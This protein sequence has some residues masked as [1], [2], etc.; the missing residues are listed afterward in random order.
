MKDQDATAT[1]GDWLRE[2]DGH[3][4]AEVAAPGPVVSVTIN[5]TGPCYHLA[6]N[7]IERLARLQGEEQTAEP[8][9]T[10]QG[11]YGEVEMD[12]VVARVASVA[13]RTRPFQVN[14]NGL[15]LLPSPADPDLL[16]LHLHV[17]RSPELIT[18]YADLKAELDGLGLRT[19]PYGPN[20]W[21]PHLTLASG[22][23]SRREVS[24]LLREVGPHLTTCQLRA[25][26]IHLNQL[27][28]TGEWHEIITF[29]LEGT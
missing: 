2:D 11:I 19:Y 24:D 18:L 21:V 27:G 4:F 12:P 16:F 7:I 14:V 8:H 9:I 17:E 26:A 22:R 29:R 5:P 3:G 20:D 25:D 13:A 6:S 10:L 15:G 1:D 23:W 28:P